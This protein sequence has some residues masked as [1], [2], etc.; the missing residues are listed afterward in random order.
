[1]AG[2]RRRRPSASGVATRWP[3]GKA[4]KA[5]A[6]PSQP[7]TCTPGLHS[8]G[9]VGWPIRRP[10]CGEASIWGSSTG[11]VPM[12][13]WALASALARSVSD[14]VSWAKTMSHS[15]KVAPR[16]C[17]R[18]ASSAS[19]LRGQGQGPRSRRLRSSMSIRVICAGAGCTG[20]MAVKRSWICP[21]MR[22]ASGTRVRLAATKMASSS[23][24]QAAARADSR[25]RR[26]FSLSCTR[27]PVYLRP[28]SVMP[29]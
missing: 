17:R 2:R 12:T 14:K 4:V 6:W 24:S 16:A 13:A 26:L 29:W 19:T 28:Q 25:G 18:R 11:M 8:G 20:L 1:M 23:S 7:Y 3:A 15:C 10:S 21:S 22:C 27:A 9:A 5:G